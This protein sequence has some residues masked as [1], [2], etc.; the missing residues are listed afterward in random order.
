[1]WKSQHYLLQDYRALYLTFPG[2]KLNSPS[3]SSS[4]SGSQEKSL[5]RKLIPTGQSDGQSTPKLLKFRAVF[6]CQN[7]KAPRADTC[8]S[9]PSPFPER[10]FRGVGLKI[11]DLNLP[12]H[13]FRRVES[14]VSLQSYLGN[15]YMFPDDPKRGVRASCFTLNFYHL[16]SPSP[17]QRPHRYSSVQLLQPPRLVFPS[18]ALSLLTLSSPPLQPDRSFKNTIVTISI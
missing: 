1:M 2:P 11:V 3:L 16:S 18:P 10:Y 9:C 17:F 12:K 13:N 14:T 15:S 6:K 4:R 8:Y 5:F 7:R